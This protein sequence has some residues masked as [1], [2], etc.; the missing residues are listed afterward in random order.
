MWTR[1]LMPSSI[2]NADSAEYNRGLIM[3]KRIITSIVA[4]FVLIPVLVFSHTWVF[5]L[6]LSV[7]GLISLYELFKCMGVHKKPAI[8]IPL[9]IY[10]AIA[11]FLLRYNPLGDPMAFALISFMVGALY[12]IY[13]FSLIVWSHG[14]LQFNDALTVFAMAAYIIAAL[15]SI[16]YVRDYGEGGKYLYLLIFIGAW[17]TDSFAYFTGYLFGKHKLIEDVSPKKTIEGSI[18]GIVF[19]ALAFVGFGLIVK[20]FAGTEANLIF[21]AISAVILSVISQIGDLIMSVVKRHYNIKDY[22][23]IFPGHGG[24]LDRFDSILAVSLGLAVVCM[25]V[26][27]TGIKLI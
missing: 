6:A 16:I 11:P 8:V 17:I 19:C 5:P 1:S 24:M 10:G 25:F 7:V 12:L 9:Y 4:I 15:N 27:L 21:L 26:T 14:K 3:L 18:G 20:H 13:L 22:G 23:K 2:E